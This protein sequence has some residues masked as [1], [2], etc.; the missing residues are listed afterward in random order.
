MK[1]ADVFALFSSI[2]LQSLND[3]L[4]SH[5][6][7]DFLSS[8]RKN[9]L[10]HSIMKKKISMLC[11]NLGLSL[12]FIILTGGNLSLANPSIEKTGGAYLTLAGKFGGNIS[13]A[14]L[15]AECKLGIEGCAKGSKIFQYS[16]YIHDK[17]YK[18]NSH[19]LSD[20][21]IAHL[22]KLEKGEEF[23]F[24]RIR[25][26]LPEGNNVDVFART[27]TVV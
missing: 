20:E 24:K 25:A 19:S 6:A 10:T 23:Y 16:L 7:Y 1:L 3:A 14:E 4:L 22:K 18:G 27:F 13:Q 21:A 5:F 8:F 2:C 9:H 12:A 17:V 11:M 26:K 15:K